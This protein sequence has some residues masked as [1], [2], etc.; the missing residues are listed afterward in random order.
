MATLKLK[1]RQPAEEIENWDD[2]D[3]FL[4]DGDDLS[5]RNSTTSANAPSRRRDSASS[6]VSFRSEVDSVQGEERQVNIPGDDDSSATDAIAAAQS[7]GIPLPKN[8]PTSALMGG[9]IKRLGGR[10]LQKIIQ[11]DWEND[12]ELPES[13]K[14][15]AIKTQDNTDFPDALRQVSAGSVQGSP[16]KPTKSP[17][18]ASAAAPAA[19]AAPAAKSTT[20]ALTSAINLDKFKDTDEDEDL[21]GDGVA[22]I[23]VPR[24]R[25][26]SKPVSFITPPTPQKDQKTK[27]TDDDFEQD[28]ELPSSGKLTLSTRRDIPKTPSTVDDL[29]WGEG[30]LGTRFG[31]TRRD[32]RSNRSSSA[33]ALSPSVSSSITAESEDETMDG[34]LLP[35]GPL[36]FQER[37]QR[38]KKSPSPARLN[39]DTNVTSNPFTKA[40]PPKQH[41]EPER[42]DMA[43]GLDLGEGD[44]FDSGKLTLHRNIK[45]KESQPAS[46]ARPKTAVSLTFTNKPQ[47][48]LPRLSHERSHS[49]A[50][51]PV[52][53]SGGPIQQQSRRSRSRLGHASQNS[54]SSVPTPTTTN[55]PPFPPA[56]PRRREITTR[57]SF[58]TLRNDASNSNTQLLRQKRSLPAVRPAN[59]PVKPSGTHRPPSRD[60][61]RPQSGMRPKTPV[62]R[63]RHAESPSLARKNPMPFLPA[64]ASQNQSQH[65]SSKGMRQFRRWDS[66]NAIDMRP[67]SRSYSRSNLRSPSPRR[68]K[69]AEDTWERLSKPKNKKNFGDGH[70]LDAF[71]DLPTSK[72]SETRYLR[73]PITTGPKA[74]LRNK[75]HQNVMPDRTATPAPSSPAKSTAASS[76]TPRFARDTAASRIARE[77]SKANR[78][79][80]NGP[81]AAVSAQRGPPLASKTNLNPQLPS[82][83]V[84]RSKKQ[85][86]R[87]QQLKPHLIANLN[88]GKESKGKHISN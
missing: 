75:V 35:D 45:V 67:T 85:S 4:L 84:V 19:P 88:S 47:S 38:R 11:E 29:D 13:S 87:P 71:D 62:E 22:T 54:T 52:S 72:E 66:D 49:T 80:T 65:A 33:S 16:T 57:S 36:N 37:L 79:P 69:V 60:N 61:N 83:N 27:V 86:K 31:G 20:S 39:V 21:F 43:D 44:V 56:T 9:T 77:T 51:E 46:P 3:D 63:I 40:S 32:G 10:K 50:L 34:L 74:S 2:D 78:V 76:A 68:Y 6:H 24:G 70:E 48:R 25:Q 30:S 18:A 15:L 59:S 1:P 73:T 5:M 42:P 7:S 81:L 53:E 12:L 64:G 23:R 8:V 28:L 26:P 41:A 55:A 17:A 58:S 14:G 82:Q